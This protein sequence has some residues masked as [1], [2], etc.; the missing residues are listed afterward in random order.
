MQKQ[1]NL[2]LGVGLI[3]YNAKEELKRTLYSL[4]PSESFNQTVDYIFIIDGAFIYNLRKNPEMSKFSSDGSIEMIQAFQR[5]YHR[6]QKRFP[7]RKYP[8]IIL[9]Q[10]ENLKDEYDKRVEYVNLCNAYD[11]NALLIIDSDEFITYHKPLLEFTR[12]KESNWNFF[13]KELTNKLKKFDGDVGHIYGIKIINNEYGYAKTYPRLWLH[14]KDMMYV[15]GSHYKFMPIKRYKDLMKRHKEYLLGSH[16]EGIVS[17]M[18]GITLKHDHNRRTEK[19]LNERALYQNYLVNYETN[20]ETN[21]KEISETSAD[22]KNIIWSPT[23][24]CLRCVIRD[25]VNVK[26]LR[27]PR[28]RQKR[29][30][31]DPFVMLKK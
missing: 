31:F 22:I 17:N 3:T 11:C 6:M 19:H 14:P 23:C 10:N 30:L 25:K 24:F 8:E 29:H 27:D 7:D 15:L 9:I 2:V 18:H 20:I 5:Y 28:P 13:R 16:I 1:E 12:L 4:T 21:N 26:K